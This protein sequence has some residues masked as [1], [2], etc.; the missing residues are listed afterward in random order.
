MAA[1][2]DYLENKLVDWFLRGQTFTP[3][4]NVHVGLYRA[5]AG[6]SPRS[7]V[8]TV[9]QTTVPAA[10][11]TV[12]QTAVER[13]MYRCTTGGT[14]GAGEPTWP[15]TNGATVTDGTAVW[16]EMTPDFEAMNSNVT[17]IE[18]SGNAYARAS[19]AGSLANWAGTQGA[20]TTVASSGSSG[21]TS[22]NGV[23]TFPTPTP[24]GWGTV[25]AMVA[26][27]AASSGNGLFF[28]VLAVPNVVNPGSPVTFP[29][30]ALSFQIDN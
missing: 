22:N 6:V 14:T 15:T 20:G 3:P 25:A 29:A 21:T 18:V 24:T 5:T 19:V 8:V 27:D 4:A 1:L 17:S 16:T 28:G 2:T 12:G 10:L 30:A 23:L 13:R 9:G 11:L 26:S 7:T